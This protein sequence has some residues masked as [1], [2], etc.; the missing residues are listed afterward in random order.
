M[1]KKEIIGVPS[2][3]VLLPMMKELGIDPLEFCLCALIDRLAHN[4]QNRTGWCYATKD[5]LADV[6][7]T[8][9]RTIY[10]SINK[11]INLSLLKRQE[12][13]SNVTITSKW[14]NTLE[15]YSQMRRDYINAKK[16]IK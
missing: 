16:K 9:E 15:A 10:R 6:L 2:V 12:N 14:M 11:L 7:N 13:T 8:S 1:G 3:D 5:H 4:S